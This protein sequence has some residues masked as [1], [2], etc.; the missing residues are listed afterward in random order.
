MKSYGF[1]SLQLGESFDGLIR[2]HL[3]VEANHL[4]SPQLAELVQPSCGDAAIG[5]MQLF[6]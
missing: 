1:E 5:E 6:D 2:E 4:Q 3:A